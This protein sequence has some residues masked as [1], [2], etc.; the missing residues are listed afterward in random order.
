[1]K[2]TY[3]GFFSACAL[4]ALGFGIISA[5]AELLVHEPFEYER[6]QG[7]VTTENPGE[8]IDGLNGGMGFSGAWFSTG[9]WNSGIPEGPGDYGSGDTYGISL[10]AR[11]APLAYVDQHSQALVTSGNQIR[12]AFGNSSWERRY[13]STP[14]GEANTTVWLSFLAQAHGLATTSPRWAF[15]ELASSDSS[16]RMWFGNVTPVSS[17]NWAIQLPDRSTGPYSAD[18]GDAYPMNVPTMYLVK[19]EFG[20][21]DKTTVS[22]WLNPADLTDESALPEPVFQV[23]T[24]FLSINQIGVAGRYSTDFDEIRI[25]STFDSVTPSEE[26]IPEEDPRLAIARDG[27]NVSLTWSATLTGFVLVSSTDLVEWN[28]VAGDPVVVEGNNTLTVPFSENRQFFRLQQA[29]P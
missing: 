20:N 28:P 24:D 14:L 27:D 4:L 10:G 17:G 19:L 8:G 1:M 23:D 6:R 9:T 7:F 21:W 15:V 29:S 16:G 3:N 13:L 26:F 2:Q 11:T 18:A 22:V 12:T 5:S 25:G